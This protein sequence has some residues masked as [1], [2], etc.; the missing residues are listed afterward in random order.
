MARSVAIIQE[1]IGQ[2]SVAEKEEVLRALLEELDGPP[3]PDVEAAWLEEVER[4]AREIDSGQVQCI[5]AEEVFRKLDTQ[6]K[7]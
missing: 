5:P 6:L 3:D 4:R 7:K 1:K 2:L